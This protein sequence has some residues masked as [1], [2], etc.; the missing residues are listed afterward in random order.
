MSVNLSAALP[1]QKSKFKALIPTIDYYFESKILT[2]G[3]RKI[4]IDPTGFDDIISALL[5]EFN[6]RTT[7]NYKINLKGSEFDLYRPEL[8]Y[9]ID[10]FERAKRIRTQKYRFKL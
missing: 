8:E 5:V 10:T 6:H 3:N 2:I 1:V 4:Q 7:D 9:L